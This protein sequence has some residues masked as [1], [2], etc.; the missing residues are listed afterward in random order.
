M[1]ED[2]SDAAAEKNV[3]IARSPWRSAAITTLSDRSTA[4]IQGY[5]GLFNTLHALFRVWL[6]IAARQRSIS[7]YFAEFEN[8]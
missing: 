6:S 2:V 1:D 8:P 3:S 4:A 7:S 5:P